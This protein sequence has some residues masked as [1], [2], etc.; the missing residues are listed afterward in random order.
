MVEQPTFLEHL[1][2]K[3]R[4]ICMSDCNYV[5]TACPGSGKTRL[6]TYRLAY[7]QE[8]YKYSRKYNI[9]ITYTNRA[10]D[11]IYRRLDDMAIDLSS[12]WSGT[13]HQFCMS[14]IIRPYAMY[15]DNLK[16]GYKVIDEYISRA[17]CKEIAE[18]L[19]IDYG[20]DNPLEYPEIKEK[21]QNR[22]IE[23]KE[24]DFDSI[25]T[26][27]LKLLKEKPF[28]AENI[29]AVV[30]SFHIDEF[31][32]T[33]E[34]QYK[35][36]SEIVHYNNK[37]NVVFV[38]DTNQAIFG[39][40]GAVA[41]NTQEIKELFGVDFKEDTLSGCYRSTQRI[42]DFYTNFEIDKTGVYSLSKNKNTF[43]VINY[44]TSIGISELT[45]RIKNIIEKELANGISENEICVVAPQW[46]Q[47]FSVAKN[48]R[49]S[50]PT[51]SFDAPEISA[52]KYDPMNPFYLLAKL[53]FTKSGKYV[54]SRKKTATEV[55]SILKYDFQLCIDGS[56]D[57][58]SLLN[59]INRCS[60]TIENGML[61]YKDAV[62]EIFL[63]MG[64]KIEEETSLMVLFES[65]VEKCNERIE[66]YKLSSSYEAFFACFAEKH[67]IVVNTIHGVK[68]EEYKTVIAFGLLNGI[69]PHWDYITKPEKKSLRY[70]ETQKLLYVLSSRAK[71]NLYLFSEKGHFTKKGNEYTPTDE[72][73]SVSFDYN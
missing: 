2:D 1:N 64:L 5:L 7:L 48:L 34:L 47:I 35:I 69:L 60:P 67:G 28:I 25:L 49:E 38:G 61:F 33:N 43:G 6:L 70:N 51:V 65:F 54:R 4:E 11:E 66:K 55:L 22:L 72:L 68:G 46:Y 9:A 26:L 45:I 40:I 32:D 3:Q 27:S 53:L 36:L 73:R 24:I 15:S 52:F 18:E 10:A 29:S 14:F 44:D 37:I 63:A 19:S 59:A 23:R 56:F 62:Q 20:Y 42:V 41:K 31:Q 17:Y 12:V 71:E 50:L 58:Y 21:Y 16:N 39:G 13:I 57:N 30:R 8:K